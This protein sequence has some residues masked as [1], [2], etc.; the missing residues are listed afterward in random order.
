MR[1]RSRKTETVVLCF[2]EGRAKKTI[3]IKPNEIVDID[4]SVYFL[5]K[6]AFKHDWLE[7][8]EEQITTEIIPVK[9]PEKVLSQEDKM[10]K[11]KKDIEEYIK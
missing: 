10:R 5:S 4:D 6:K 3:S 11:A 9:E 2:V 1:L 7:I 8:L